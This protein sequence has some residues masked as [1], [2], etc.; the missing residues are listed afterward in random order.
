M[1]ND[2]TIQFADPEV[3]A[4]PLSVSG[5]SLARF[6]AAVLRNYAEKLEAATD[7]IAAQG[8]S[9]AAAQGARSALAVAVGVARRTALALETRAG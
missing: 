4:Q 6:G 1:S 5:D 8:T 9:E 2:R 3:F 7:N